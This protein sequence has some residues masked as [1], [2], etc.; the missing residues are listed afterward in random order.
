M[1]LYRRGGKRVLDITLVLLSLPIALSLGA[2]LLGLGAVFFRGKPL[3]FQL[4]TGQKSVDFQLVKF[5][6]MPQ[7]TETPTWYGRLLRRTSLDELP[8][9]GLVLLGQ[10]S[11]VGPRP[12][13]PA[14]RPYYTA[15]EATRHNVRPGI[16]GLAQVQGRNVLDWPT[17][18]ELDAQYAERCSL[19]LDLWI[20]A[21]TLA[22]V[23]AGGSNAGNELPRLDEVSATKVVE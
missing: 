18:L 21:R 1:G 17:R 7:G 12:L 13:F 14:Y 4:R 8:Q 22:Q 10:M 19:R 5:R 15:R 6:S 2:V 23:V 9:L 20:L 16:T 3:F 11:L